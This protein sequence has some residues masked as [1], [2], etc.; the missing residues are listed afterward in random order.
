M[1]NIRGRHNVKSLWYLDQSIFSPSPSLDLIFA[2]PMIDQR[3]THGT[4]EQTVR[5]QLNNICR[6]A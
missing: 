3:P 6:K 5:K 1:L 4:A 2:L